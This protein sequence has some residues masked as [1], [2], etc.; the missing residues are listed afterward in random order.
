MLR[1]PGVNIALSE[2][3]VKAAIKGFLFAPV[4]YKAMRHMAE[5]RKE[6]GFR[7]IFNVLGPLCNPL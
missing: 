2:A 4:F 3:A 1:Q 5:L 7:T 6:L